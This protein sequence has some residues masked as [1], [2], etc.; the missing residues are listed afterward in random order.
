MLL[1]LPKGIPTYQSATGNWTRPDNMWR[2]NIPK[3]P[4]LHCDI[5]P[6]IWPPLA[7]HMPIIT[8]INMPF[9]RATSAH[10]LDFRQANWIKVNKY[11]VQRL[12]SG[13]LPLRIA[14]KD[15][16]ITKVDELVHIIKDVLEDHLKERCPSPFKHCWWT[17]ELSQLK[18]QQN[19][20]SSKAY[21]FCHLR[22]HPVHNEYKAAT[23]KFKDT[24][25]ETWNQDWS[26]WLEAA[27][28]QVLYITNKY[29]S[30]EPTDYSNTWVPSLCT[31]TNNLLSTADDNSDKVLRNR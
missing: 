4:I 21:K 19:W 3:D 5:V 2:S 6:A 24:M 23:V 12:E 22:D 31:T 27:S 10:S 30:N 9:P 17:K 20:L 25:Q 26:D 28:Q 16:F 29:I 11:L 18:K 14:S 15:E 1:A 8:I 7:D 13:P